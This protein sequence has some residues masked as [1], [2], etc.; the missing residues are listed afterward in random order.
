[1]KTSL[2]KDEFPRINGSFEFKKMKVY[3]CFRNFLKE[4]L[5]E[6]QKYFEIIVWSSSQADYSES[7]INIIQDK[8]DFKFDYIFTL[9]DQT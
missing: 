3:I 2:F 4:F 1:M 6:A 8:L 9:A 7:L 5:F